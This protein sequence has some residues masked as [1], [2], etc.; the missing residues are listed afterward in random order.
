MLAPI[1]LPPPRLGPSRLTRTEK[2][3]CV[4]VAQALTNEQ[5]AEVRGCCRYTVSRHLSNICDKLGIDNRVAVAMH[6]VRE[7]WFKP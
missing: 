4:L 5:I 7:G 2:D 1:V 6:A 3:V